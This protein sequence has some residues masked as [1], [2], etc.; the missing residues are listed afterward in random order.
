MTPHCLQ[1]ESS[2]RQVGASRTHPISVVDTTRDCSIVLPYDLR[3]DLLKCLLDRSSSELGEIPISSR[4]LMDQIPQPTE[5]RRLSSGDRR[6]VHHTPVEATRF[7]NQ[8][9]NGQRIPHVHPA[10]L[11]RTMISPLG[12]IFMLRRAQGFQRGF[13]QRPLMG[14]L[15][16]ERYFVLISAT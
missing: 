10:V 12:C 14:R 13:R 6:F 3:R 11:F 4:L 7:R 2:D 16:F 5:L 9:C 1:T 8:W 15:V